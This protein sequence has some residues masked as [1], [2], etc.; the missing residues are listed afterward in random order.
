MTWR[1]HEISPGLVLWSIV[2]LILAPVLVMT[3]ADPDLWG[4]VRFGL[5]LLA[6]HRL[7]SVDPYSFTQ[8][9]PWINH[10]W[11]SELLMGVAY[12]SAGATGL[13]LLKGMLVV[14]FPL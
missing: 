3:S 13:A 11:L 14:V 12:Q 7:P 8:D 2:G 10:E 1:L 9:I 4:H 5:D 6:Q